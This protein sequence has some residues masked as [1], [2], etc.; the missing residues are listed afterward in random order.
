MTQ[1]LSDLEIR[2]L[3]ARLSDPDALPKVCE[4]IGRQL[5]DAVR[6]QPF[7]RL[8]EVLTALSYGLGFFRGLSRQPPKKN[9]F[10]CTDHALA[11]RAEL[12]RAIGE[13]MELE[14]D[15][16][17]C[18]SE[19]DEIDEFKT[20]MG[21]DGALKAFTDKYDEADLDEMLDIIGILSDPNAIHQISD[22]L[23][24]AQGVRLDTTLY[25][26]ALMFRAAGERLACLT[27]YRHVN[28]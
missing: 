26:Q 6:N 7:D 21:F 4:D 25:S 1:P 19:R 23:L 18:Q 9:D 20:L 10:N 14:S 17:T 5:S 27:Q 8:K 24:D 12:Y 3:A 16:S 13:R 15:R 2:S 11:K 22:D 28:P